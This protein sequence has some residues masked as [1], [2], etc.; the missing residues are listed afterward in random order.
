[1]HL[2]TQI[3]AEKTSNSVQANLCSTQL[4][5]G[6]VLRRVLRG[7]VQFHLFPHLILCACVCGTVLYL[8][9]DGMLGW[10]WVTF[11]DYFSLVVSAPVDGHTA[12]MSLTLQA[13]PCMTL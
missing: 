7:F 11:L 4:H 13:H 9:M 8:G 5:P 3:A 6:P 10:V 1:M 12:Y 2:K